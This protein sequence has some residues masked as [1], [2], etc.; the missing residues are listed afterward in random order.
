MKIPLQIEK[1]GFLTV[2]ATLRSP[3]LRLFRTVKFIVDTGSP[4]T[5]LSMRT[6]KHSLQFSGSII[7]SDLLESCGFA[8]YFN[9][10]KKM[11]YFEAEN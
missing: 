6:G 9:P 8:L 10:S 3:R 7:G 5:F 2:F 1:S 4:K 11:A